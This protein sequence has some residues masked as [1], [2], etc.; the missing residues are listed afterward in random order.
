[1]EIISWLRSTLAVFLRKSELLRVHFGSFR[2]F[3]GLIKIKHIFVSVQRH[4]SIAL[5]IETL[6]FQAD[7]N[8]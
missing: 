8:W 4:K 5:S 7:L 6:H 3:K 2:N 1:M